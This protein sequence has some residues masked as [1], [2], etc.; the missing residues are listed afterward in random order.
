[1][2]VSKNDKHKEYAR[3]AEHCLKLVPTIPDQEYRTIQREMAAE[4]LRLADAPASAKANEVTQDEACDLSWRLH[5]QIAAISK[6]VIALHAGDFKGRSP[7]F[8]RCRSYRRSE[9][10]Q[11]SIPWR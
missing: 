7:A 11:N 10:R 4:W 1:M 2:A 3:Y 9:L 8:D 6:S 5:L